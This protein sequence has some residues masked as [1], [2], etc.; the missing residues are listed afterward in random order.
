MEV[1]RGIFLAR[2]IGLVSP[3]D[4]YLLRY[5]VSTPRVITPVEVALHVTY[6][7]MDSAAVQG[8]HGALGG[9]RIVVLHKAVVVAL[10]L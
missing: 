3:V 9:T 1:A 7:L 4:S 6:G 2:G 5:E 8:L 10:G